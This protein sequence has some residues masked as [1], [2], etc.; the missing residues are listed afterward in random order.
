MTVNLNLTNNQIF[1]SG[2]EEDHRNLELVFEKANV[3]PEADEYVM[4]G[5]EGVI[6]TFEYEWE[7][8]KVYS[9]LVEASKTAV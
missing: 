7:F 9:I 3:S 8:A 5:E 4:D 6:Y 2:D 1:L